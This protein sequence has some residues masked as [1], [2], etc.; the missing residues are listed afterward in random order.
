MQLKQYVASGKR[1]SVGRL[2]LTFEIKEIYGD[3]EYPV[4]RMVCY[5]TKESDDNGE[6]GLRIPYGESNVIPGF[7]PFLSKEDISNI[8]DALAQESK[9]TRIRFVLDDEMTETEGV[10]VFRYYEM[11]VLRSEV[12]T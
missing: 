4:Y 9:A 8:A 10:G 7:H 1:F 12:V 11:S 5:S 6:N 3:S 2:K